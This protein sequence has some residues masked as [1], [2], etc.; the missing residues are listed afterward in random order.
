MRFSDFPGS[1]FHK[2]KNRKNPYFSTDSIEFGENLN[3]AL[4]R[5]RANDGF[6]LA[7]E[8]GFSGENTYA[9]WRNPLKPSKMMG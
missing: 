9:G 8:V 6:R 5:L 3:Q 1:I 7:V 2:K 4:E